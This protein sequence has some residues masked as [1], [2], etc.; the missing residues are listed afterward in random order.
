MN[1]NKTKQK[2]PNFLTPKEFGFFLTTSFPGEHYFKSLG[3]FL[4]KI[5]VSIFKAAGMIK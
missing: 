2:P 4:C 1:E 3:F 5:M